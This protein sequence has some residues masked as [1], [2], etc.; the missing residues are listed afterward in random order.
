VI[1]DGRREVCHRS[2]VLVGSEAAS[3]VNAVEQS[4]AR[5]DPSERGGCRVA[6]CID[7]ERRAVIQQQV[8]N[9]DRLQDG[10]PTAVGDIEQCNP[11]FKCG[12]QRRLTGWVGLVDEVLIAISPADWLT[13]WRLVS[14]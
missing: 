10:N 5:R 1:F 9:D 12:K 14:R 13:R 8:I 2:I 3:D 7:P 6:V 4:S 11:L